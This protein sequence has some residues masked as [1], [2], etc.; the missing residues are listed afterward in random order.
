[1]NVSEPVRTLKNSKSLFPRLISSFVQDELDCRGSFA[2]YPAMV[3]NRISNHLDLLGP[4]LPVD[5]ACSS[6][7]T[8]MH[9]AVQAIASGDCN[10]AVVGGCQLNHRQVPINNVTKI[11]G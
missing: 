11:D 5:T 2:G 6:T 10:A 9:L 4:S 8:A 3:A 7:L 1:M